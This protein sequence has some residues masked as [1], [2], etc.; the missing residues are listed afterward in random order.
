MSCVSHGVILKRVKKEDAAKVKALTQMQMIGKK[1]KKLESSD[2]CCQV[3]WCSYITSMKENMYPPE[4]ATAQS[5]WGWG[6]GTADLAPSCQNIRYHNCPL[7]GSDPPDTAVGIA[8]R[9]V[10]PNGGFLTLGL[11]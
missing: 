7:A 6:D 8:E 9:A 5:G 1:K 3:P 10:A 2:G 4:T 11:R